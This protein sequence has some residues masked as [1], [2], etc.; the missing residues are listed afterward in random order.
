MN[1][2]IVPVGV[3]SR[4]R[5]VPVRG[6]LLNRVA[7]TH[8][9]DEGALVERIGE[10]GAASEIDALQERGCQKTPCSPE[11]IITAQLQELPRTTLEVD[12]ILRF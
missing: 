10:T 12:D 2:L 6:D 4:K 11:N 8:V 7:A 3:L 9:V 1:I 5:G